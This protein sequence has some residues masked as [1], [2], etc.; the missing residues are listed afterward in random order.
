MSVPQL[1]ELLQIAL[2]LIVPRHFGL[3][4]GRQRHSVR[5]AAIRRGAEIHDGVHP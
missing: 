1:H 4:R 3:L 5:H 2:D